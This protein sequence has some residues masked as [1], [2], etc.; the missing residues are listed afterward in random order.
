MADKIPL[1]VTVEELAVV[2]AVCNLYVAETNKH[3]RVDPPS[4]ETG[5]IVARRVELARGIA[6]A[7][8]MTGMVR[9]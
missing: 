6:H 7:I 3:L 9:V 1:Y 8:E 5:E 4:R 2:A